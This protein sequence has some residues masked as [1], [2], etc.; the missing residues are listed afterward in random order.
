MKKHPIAARILV[1]AGVHPFKV[2]Y[3]RSGMDVDFAVRW[4]WYFEYLAAR[5][6]VANPRRKV[7]L[8]IGKQDVLLGEVWVEYHKK[9]LLKHRRA[10]LAKLEKGVVEDDLF[11]FNAEKNREQIQKVKDDIA[12][13][14]NGTY[15][16]VKFPEYVNH[17]KDWI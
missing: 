11:G 5:V 12:Q 1:Y 7:E 15:P 17:I 14:E 4:R 9:N 3:L 13:L 8:Y 10:K 6:K 16:I 2:V